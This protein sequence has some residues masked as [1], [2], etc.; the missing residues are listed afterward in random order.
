M[1]DNWLLE[2][3][4]NQYWSVLFLYWHRL[5]IGTTLAIEYVHGTLFCW[6]EMGEIKDSS[7]ELELYPIC[8]VM[9]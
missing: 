3:H 6:K 7:L 9:S 1:A 5:G 8:F 4:S 2:P